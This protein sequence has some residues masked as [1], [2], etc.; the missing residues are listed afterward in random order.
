MS[1]NKNSSKLIVSGEDVESEDEEIDT[2][3]S[4]SIAVTDVD[5]NIKKSSSST[6]GIKIV[7][8]GEN[9]TA[10]SDYEGIY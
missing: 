1:S 5:G 2:A 6:T 9:S 4:P 8:F 10:E 7:T 3:Q